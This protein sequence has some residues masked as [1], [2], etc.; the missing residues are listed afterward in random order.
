M[1]NILRPDSNVDT[2]ERMFEEVKKNLPFF[3]L[4]VFPEKIKKED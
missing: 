1:D 4:K 2:L 3:F